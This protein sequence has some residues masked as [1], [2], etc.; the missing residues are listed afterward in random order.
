M[1]AGAEHHVQ[2][3]PT[4]DHRHRCCCHLRRRDCA[5]SCGQRSHLIVHRVVGM[6]R[7]HP[8]WARLAACGVTLM[9]VTGCGADQPASDAKTE[10]MAPTTVAEDTRTDFMESLS[11][12]VDQVSWPTAYEL[13]EQQIW[14]LV[15]P[16]ASTA[17]LNDDSAQTEV[18]ILNQCAW[19]LEARDALQSDKPLDPAVEGLGATAALMPGSETFLKG[20]TDD[21]SAG[22]SEKVAEFITANTCEAG[23][24]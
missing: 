5:S 8:R 12:Y 17:V 16:H 11:K 20:L 2:R 23:Y 4:D 19:A 7:V 21:I 15:E 1:T 10:P 18:G 3:D 13:D 14:A 6:I 9:A 24:Q 22:G